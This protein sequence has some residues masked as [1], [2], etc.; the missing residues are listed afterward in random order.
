MSKEYDTLMDDN[1]N[2]NGNEL[3]QNDIANEFINNN[4]MRDDI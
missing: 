1:E 4:T 3:N 2:L